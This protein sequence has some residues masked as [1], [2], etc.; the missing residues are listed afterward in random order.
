[1]Q[2]C[3]KNQIILDWVGSKTKGRH[4]ATLDN[5]QVRGHFSCFSSTETTQ[6]ENDTPTVAE[7][8]ERF[9][10]KVRAFQFWDS[11]SNALNKNADMPEGVF[12]RGRQ[13]QWDC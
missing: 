10:K 11:P 7:C 3:P 5:A 1:M 8:C 2:C 4:G 9:G 12:V 13:K 6:T